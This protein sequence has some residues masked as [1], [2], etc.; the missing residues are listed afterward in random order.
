M[1]DTQ[2]RTAAVLSG[3]RGKVRT[4]AASATEKVHGVD[5][6]AFDLAVKRSA[7]VSASRPAAVEGLQFPQLTPNN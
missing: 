4:A 6:Y 3:R 2:H 1:E 5:S 7:R